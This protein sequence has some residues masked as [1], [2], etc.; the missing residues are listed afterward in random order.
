MVGKLVAAVGAVKASATV[1][2]GKRVAVVAGGKG[3]IAIAGVTAVAADGVAS[4]S[5]IFSRELYDLQKSKAFLHSVL[6]QHCRL[7]C[8]QTKMEYRSPESCGV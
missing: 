1:A 4:P 2:G 6:A 5:L 3:A 7:G 8:L